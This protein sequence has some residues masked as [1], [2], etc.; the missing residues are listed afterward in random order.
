MSSNRD[1]FSGVDQNDPKI[2]RESFGTLGTTTAPGEN[3]LTQLQAK[4]RQG[5]KHVELHLMNHGKGQWGKLD[6][7]D[8]YGYEQKRA[9]MQLAKLNKQTLSVHAAPDGPTSFSGLSNGGF[10]ENQRAKLSKEIDETVKFASQ[11]AKGGAVVF[12]LNETQLATPSSEI[13]LSQKYLDDLKSGK[14]GDFGKKDYEKNLKDDIENRD[15][16]DRKFVDNIDMFSNLKI[17]YE[18]LDENKKNDFEKTYEEDILKYKNKGFS[19]QDAKIRA[20]ARRDYIERIKNTDQSLVAVGNRLDKVERIKKIINIDE[21][22]NLNN[23]NS[24]ESDEKKY[25]E[26]KK[27]NID[28]LD[29][30]ELQKLR[31]V[32]LNGFES[33]DNDKKVLKKIQNKFL[34]TYENLFEKNNDMRY[35][36]DRDFYEAEKKGE[37]GLLKKQKEDLNYKYEM[38]K[39]EIERIKVLELENKKNLFEYNKMPEN[40]KEEKV[41]KK[42]YAEKIKE[43]NTYTQQLKYQIVGQED[44]QELRNYND[45]IAQINEQITENKKRIEN[46][47]VLTEEIF[48]KNTQTIA[49]FG[50]NAMENQL[51]MYEKSQK[52]LEEKKEIEKEIKEKEKELEETFDGSKRAK[53]FNELS[54]K[55]HSLRLKTGLSDYSDIISE[56]NGKKEIVNPLYIAPENLIA[57]FGYMTNLEEYKA[58]IRNSWVNFSDKLL[59]DDSKYKKIK[60][61]YEN[62]LGD[63]IDTKEK[64]LEIAK[65]HIGGTFDNAHA[66]TWLKYFKREDGE[67]E[68]DRIKRFNGWLNTQAEDMYKEGIVKHIH[69]NDSMGKDDDHNMLGSGI[70]DIHDLRERLRN[71]G[72]KEAMI[73]EAGGRGA[74]DNLHLLNAFDV[75]NVSIRNQNDDSYKTEIERREI[76]GGVSDWVSVKRDYENRPQ[77]SQYGMGYSTF[78]N[79]PSQNKNLVGGWSG[80]NLL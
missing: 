22:G 38:H 70:L 29:I 36:T 60:E 68:E 44:Y 30:D 58:V 65:K 53:I 27:I 18:N 67:S 40:T 56:K 63:K 13:N 57:G 7:P 46:T 51:S 79:S 5:V 4:I 24:L 37:I 23:I 21:N 31:A 34:I 2:F 14:F 10:D 41:A 33:K 28:N 39:D 49:D 45:R 74:N 69:F 50:L 12:H 80:V 54:K 52:S 25:L 43:N 9:I 15:N 26:D 17:E 1:Y 35:K 8:K 3:Q 20:Y 76:G 32:L 71:A 61:H 6:T 75:L 64:A 72:L 59:S 16:F 55:K 62:V 48:N 42:I 19:N 66:A 47:K 73:V 78:K 77:F 11:T